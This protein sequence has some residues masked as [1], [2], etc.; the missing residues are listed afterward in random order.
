MGIEGVS[1]WGQVAWLPSATYSS[2]HSQP[3]VGW[4]SSDPS[5]QLHTRSLSSVLPRTWWY[6]R[7]AKGLRVGNFRAGLRS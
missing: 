6:P 4:P 7:V 5:P 3:A 1:A 2:H